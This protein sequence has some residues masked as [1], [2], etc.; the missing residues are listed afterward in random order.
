MA[1]LA[2]CVLAFAAHAQEDAPVRTEVAEQPAQQQRPAP[3]AYL[4]DP[5]KLLQVYPR[6]AQEYRRYTPYYKALAVLLEEKEVV[7][8]LAFY[9][10]WCKDSRREIPRLLK[11]ADLIGAEQKA[12]FYVELI[13]VNRK[14]ERLDQGRPVQISKT[15]TLVVYRG[16]IEVGRIEEKARP[17]TAMAV[18]KML[19]AAD[20]EPTP[21]GLSKVWR[22]RKK[23]ET[24]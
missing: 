19:Q 18:V 21:E 6:Y 11:L 5:Q 15:P 17:E 4:L 22:A 2:L 16:G 8:V 13:P 20:G 24:Q 3:P 12:D 14:L 10:I 9:G 1:S 7:E 23:P